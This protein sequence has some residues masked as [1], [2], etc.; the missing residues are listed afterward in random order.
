MDPLQAGRPMDARQ[1]IGNGLIADVEAPFAEQ[2]SRLPG[3]G[4]VRVVVGRV[5]RPERSRRSNH[6]LLIPGS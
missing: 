1:A 5:R 2:A 4:R 6:D 3:E